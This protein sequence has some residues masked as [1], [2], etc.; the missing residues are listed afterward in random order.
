MSDVISVYAPS[1]DPYDGYGRVALELLWHLSEKGVQVNVLGTPKTVIDHD[2]QS[3]H[4]RELL[5][6]PIQPT[7]GGL[8]IGYPTLRE[9][10]SPMLSE[11]PSV[12]IT[13]FESTG[14]PE[15][16]VASLNQCKAVIVPSQW[17]EKA[18]RK[19]G[20]RVPIYV[21]PLGVS[22]TFQYIDRGIRRPSAERPY[23]FTFVCWGD[24]GMRKGWDVAVKAFVQAFGEVIPATDEMPERYQV[25]RDDVKLI[26]K[27]R[28]DNFPY[29]FEIDQIEV[30]TG[31]FDEYEMRDF[32]E[33]IDCMVFPSRGEGFGLP[34]REF[35]ATGGAVIATEWW[36]DDIQQ[37]GY[38]IH[39]E[40]TRAWTKHPRHDGLG[41]W[42]EPSVEHL[43]QQMQHVVTQNPKLMRHMGKRSAGRVRKLYNWQR[44]AEQVWE[45]WETE[46]Q[47]MTLAEKRQ[48]RRER[49]RG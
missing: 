18:F 39:Y 46:S 41:K 28:E 27:A 35:A 37:W 25:Q 5:K 4:I 42:A 31:D 48:A 7:V 47:R 36:A 44:F 17:C 43:V 20:V 49:K 14:L 3:E 40:M 29:P 12:A 6:R 26:I 45:I 9:R 8:M 34:P 33:A 19:N 23:T 32:Y 24:R 15:G 30:V 1:Y 21:V 11:G 10:Y 16:W 13:M 38:P 22:E 2:G